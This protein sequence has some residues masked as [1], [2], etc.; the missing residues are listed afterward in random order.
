MPYIKREN[1]PKFDPIVE[2]MAKIEV[3][4]DG[5]LNYIIFK[6]CKHHYLPKQYNSLKNYLGELERV[7]HEIERKILDPYEDEKE[8]IN[9]KI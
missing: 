1:R 6:Y 8:K 3:K 9:G 4:A 2:L 7:I 5:D